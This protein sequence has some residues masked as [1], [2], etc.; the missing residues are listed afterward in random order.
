MLFGKLDEINYMLT[1]QLPSMLAYVSVRYVVIYLPPWLS[2]SVI[3]SYLYEYLAPERDFGEC[4]YKIF[5]PLLLWVS[6]RRHAVKA[7][8]FK[9]RPSK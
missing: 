8:Y 4:C 6:G 9:S 3:V 7:L 5:K 1:C 2:I